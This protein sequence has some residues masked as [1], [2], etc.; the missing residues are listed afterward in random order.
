MQYIFRT[1]VEENFTVLKNDCIRDKNLTWE[2]RGVLHYFLSRPGDWEVT[3]KDLLEQS[4]NAKE[5]TLARIMKELETAKYIIRKKKRNKHGHWCWVTLVFDTP[6]TEEAMERSK[7]D[8]DAEMD[9]ILGPEILARTKKNKEQP[10]T[11]PTKEEV[12]VAA[13]GVG[14]KDPL[15]GYPVHVKELL[16]EFIKASQIPPTKRKKAD[17]I[18]TADEWR[19][20]GVKV[21]DIKKMY[22]HAVEGDWDIARPGSIT[23]AYYPMKKQGTKVDKKDKYFRVAE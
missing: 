21:A 4:P 12:K 20:M 1:K 14:E 15:E 13:L 23:S 10:S 17:W 16:V 18:T 2:A 6:L 5:H 19:E 11:M 22:D 3:M 7:E 8:I 9:A